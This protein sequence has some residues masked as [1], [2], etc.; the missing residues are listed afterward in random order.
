MYRLQIYDKLRYFLEFSYQGTHYHGWQIQPN[1]ISVQEVLEKSIGLL[2]R[3]T[4]K[5]TGAGRTD[6]GVHA[7]QMFAHFDVEKSIDIPDLVYKLNSFLPK[8]IAVKTIHPVSD[9]AH[10]RFGAVSRRYDY[11]IH[12]KKDPFLVETSWYLSKDLDVDLMNQAAG[13]LLQYKDFKSFSKNH[14]DVK[15]YICDIK[16]TFWTQQGHQLI[17]T[18]TADRFLRNMVR[19]IVGTLVHVGLHKIN[20]K[21]FEK[22]I[23]AR[24]RRQAGFSVPA[25]GLFLTEINYPNQI[26]ITY[27]ND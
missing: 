18:I 12:T 3:K 21:D 1:A 4:I 13:I 25:Q 5:I 24:D 2:L 7:R 27:G 15:T 22:I 20:I 14:T 10:A 9:S 8:D 16:N 17:F 23:K 26:F 6:T 11:V 19:A